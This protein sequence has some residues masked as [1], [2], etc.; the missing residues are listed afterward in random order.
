MEDAAAELVAAHADLEMTQTGKCRCKVTGHEMV[1]QR[2]VI[3]AHL[4]GKRYRKMKA[5][6]A[7]AQYDFA[8]HEPHIVQNKRDPK[9]LFCHRT[10]LHLNRVP[11]EVEVHVKGRRFRARLQEWEDKQQRRAAKAAK[12]QQKADAR[13][14]AKVDRE[15][16]GSDEDEDPVLAKFA[17]LAGDDSEVED[18]DDASS[19]DEVPEWNGK[20]PRRKA[21]A[22]ESDG[23]NDETPYADS[24][25]EGEE[26]MD[27]ARAAKEHYNRGRLAAQAQAQQ[28]ATEAAADEDQEG[29]DFEVVAGDS[30]SGGDAAS[31]REDAAE[32]SGEGADSEE[33]EQLTAAKKLSMARHAARK[34]R[35]AASNGESHRSGSAGA[36]EPSGSEPP[37]EDGPAVVG[38]V[39]GS[40][41]SDS[42]VGVWHHGAQ[43]S[44]HHGRSKDKR[45]VS[46]KHVFN[47]HKHGGS[48]GVDSKGPAGKK[49][50]YD[51]RRDGGAA[52][53]KKKSGGIG[54]FFSGNT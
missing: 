22:D 6:E 9:K 42:T 1:P 16:A 11:E 2:G 19:D 8:Q 14:A 52:R 29:S 48:Q 26:E 47:R 40:S 37:A 36:C 30:S 51:G 15:R 18:D 54:R 35:D 32:S 50:A 28:N 27:H 31:D 25:A 4:A 43:V 12:T 10:K 24:D 53:K 7:A 41:T 38:A 5:Q 44:K 23:S 39:T 49:R 3:E 21:K 33:E 13:A 34:E 46:K 17:H 45:H 20:Q